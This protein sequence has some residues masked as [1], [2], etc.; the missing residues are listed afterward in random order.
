MV[1]NEVEKQHMIDVLTEIEKQ[2]KAD[3]E[4]IA[5]LTK[6]NAKLKYRINILLR[7]LEAAE[8]AAEKA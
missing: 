8:K 3:E 6:E 7:E 1:A 4:K 2:G 5:A